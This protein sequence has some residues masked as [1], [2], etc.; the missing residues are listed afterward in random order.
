MKGEDLREGNSP[1]WFNP[2]EVV[3]VVRYLQ[4]VQSG[5]GVVSND[6]GIITLYRKQAGA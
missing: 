2:A 6:I 1:S 3:Q 5:Q 4:G